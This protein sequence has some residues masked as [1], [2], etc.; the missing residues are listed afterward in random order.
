MHQ[1]QVLFSG[2]G[3]VVWYKPTEGLYFCL[4]QPCDFVFDLLI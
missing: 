3:I 1:C 4:H 2:S